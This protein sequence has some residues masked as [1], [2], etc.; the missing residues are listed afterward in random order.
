MGDD[1]ST[2]SEAIWP[3]PRFSFQVKWGSN[4]MDFQEA[5][6]LATEAQPIEYRG[7]GSI[8][9]S[10]VKMPG[11]KGTCNVILKN[12]VCKSGNKFWEWFNQIKMNTIVRVPVTI[13]LLD[14]S[15]SAAMVWTLSNAWPG[16]ITVA[17][18]KSDGDEVAI[19]S[20]EIAHEGLMIPQS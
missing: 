5:S 16:K 3:L 13:R 20:L 8:G 2:Q 6:G 4:V 1:G 19:E 12:G 18:L 17:D 14:E 11:M 10:T 7:D 15:G 9:L